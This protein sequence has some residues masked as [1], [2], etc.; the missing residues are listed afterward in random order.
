MMPSNT[1]EEADLLDPQDMQNLDSSRGLGIDDEDVEDDEE[2]LD[3]DEQDVMNDMQQE[4][5]PNENDQE[6]LEEED[7]EEEEEEEEEGENDEDDGPNGGDDNERD[8]DDGDGVDD[9][10]DNDDDDDDDDDEDD[11]GDDDD[12][13]ADDDE[14]DNDDGDDEEDEE[15]DRDNKKD[16]GMDDGENENGGDD[17]KNK[18]HDVMDVDEE[19]NGFQKS[20]PEPEES[21]STQTKV[22]KY[23]TNLLHSASIAT[24]YNV[25]PTVAI[26]LSTQI[27]SVCLS[28]GLKYL[29]L[30]GADG[31]IR[32]YDF[33]NSIDGKLSLTML[34]KHSLVDSISYAGILSSYW[35][36]EVPQFKSD[37]HIFAN[38]K[39]GDEYTPKASPVMSMDVQ[40][41]CMFLLAGHQNGAITLQGVRYRQGSIAHYFSPSETNGHTDKVNFLKL[42]ND[43]QRFFS[44]SWD[45]KILEWDLNTGKLLNK[46]LSPHSQISSLEFRP[47]NSLIDL[48]ATDQKTEESDDDMDSLFGDESEAEE[49]RKTESL[50]S[51]KEFRSTKSMPKSRI[52]KTT[53]KANYDENAFLTSKINGQCLLW[54]RR[55]SKSPVMELHR[56]KDTPPWAHSATWSADGSKVYVGRRNACVEEFDLK[57]G[58]TIPSQTLRFPNISGPVSCVQSL[59][60]NRHILCASNDNIRLYDLNW[61]SEKSKNPFLI[62]PGHH[63]GMISNIYVDPTS[64]Y[65]VTTSGNKCWQGGSTDIAFIYDIDLEF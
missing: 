13:G 62:I 45:Q 34:Q 8:V 54:D 39:T 57:M 64:R 11:N 56:G 55:A 28:K 22:F 9:D 63:G 49:D 20:L 52:N 44:A 51:K 48:A 43:E 31:F 15:D 5:E 14:D 18:D 58:G 33:L 30:G 24:S 32:K 37:V 6:E 1:D 23:Q 36:N 46:Y 53:L 40:S 59:P 61:Q 65:M 16:E 7:E 21:D 12:D 27:H 42:S 26:H 10:D 29:F 50:S 4:L 35:P 2:E 41:E 60:N 38:R 25:Y 3:D 19:A 47:V 17:S